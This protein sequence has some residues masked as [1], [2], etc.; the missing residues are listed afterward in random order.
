MVIIDEN[1]LPCRSTY[2][3]VLRKWYGTRK[4]MYEKRKAH[5]LVEKEN[6]IARLG[7]KV[8]FIELATNGTLPILD[9][10]Q[11]RDQKVEAC[12]SHGFSQAHTETFMQMSV[13][14][15]SSDKIE[16]LKAALEKKQ[17]DRDAYE[18]KG[19]NE[20]WLGEIEV[21]ESE[22]ENNMGW[23]RP[24]SNM[25][26]HATECFPQNDGASMKKSIA[27]NKE[28]NNNN[29]S[30]K[31]KSHAKN[32]C[33]QCGRDCTTHNILACYEPRM[34][35]YV[36]AVKQGQSLETVRKEMEN[37]NNILPI[38]VDGFFGVTAK[39]QKK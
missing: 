35:P 30:R 5:V 2:A 18:K 25:M 24:Q 16:A 4:S 7:E 6:E 28:A 26:M 37:D 32:I 13:G 27:A 19:V 31:R 11:T 39:K 38:L 20:I 33:D 22:L 21:L 9:F 1:N 17:V 34:K 15:F 29:K 8:R 3:N 23:E 10:Q 14:T 12:S 36:A